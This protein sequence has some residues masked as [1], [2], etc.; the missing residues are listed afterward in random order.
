MTPAK[1]RQRGSEM[2]QRCSEC[3]CQTPLGVPMQ[4]FAFCEHMPV[5]EVLAN[6]RLRFTS[7]N[8]V[9]VERAYMKRGEFEAI[10][11]GFSNWSS[12]QANRL[13]REVTK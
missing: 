2:S 5:H 10:L 8:S 9:P 3:G 6:M 13:G 12:I 11:A 7:G 4:H 1:P